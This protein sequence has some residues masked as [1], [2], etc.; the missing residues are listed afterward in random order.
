MNLIYSIDINNPSEDTKTFP[1]D[2]LELILK[3]VTS[4][5][6]NLQRFHVKFSL[7]G[8]FSEEDFTILSIFLYN[9]I[10]KLY[11]ETLS[12]LTCA[13]ELTISFHAFFPESTLMVNFF[14][15]IIFWG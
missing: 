1:F 9:T 7:N 13:C 2:Q 14:I 8:E 10:N 15:I 11:N 5:C 4:N 3:F 6:P 12:N